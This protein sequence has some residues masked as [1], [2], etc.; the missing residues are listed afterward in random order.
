MKP[1]IGRQCSAML[2][3]SLFFVGV[4]QLA[5][6]QFHADGNISAIKQKFVSVCP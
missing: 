1:R 3:I 2:T 6:S 5:S 4:P